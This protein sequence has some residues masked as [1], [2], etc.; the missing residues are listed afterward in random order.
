MELDMDIGPPLVL[1]RSKNLYQLQYMARRAAM[2]ITGIYRERKGDHT[3]YVSRR[4]PAT[5]STSTFECLTTRQI[6]NELH[7]RLKIFDIDNV[8]NSI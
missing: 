7:R 3:F 4:R 5:A 1:M 6:G 8:E 2:S